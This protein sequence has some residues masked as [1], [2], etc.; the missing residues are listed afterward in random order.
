MDKLRQYIREYVMTLYQAK[1]ADAD[2]DYQWKHP[3]DVEHP[4]QPEDHDSDNKLPPH[5]T[6]SRSVAKPHF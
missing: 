6:R 5:F 3:S 4:L 1:I 2:V